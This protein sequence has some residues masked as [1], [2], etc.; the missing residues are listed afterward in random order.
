ME[1]DQTA[2]PPGPFPFVWGPKSAGEAGTVQV[3]FLNS[4][5]KLSLVSKCGAFQGGQ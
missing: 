1:K 4:P 5:Q 2:M 3:L